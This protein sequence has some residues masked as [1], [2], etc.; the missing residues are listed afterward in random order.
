MTAYPKLF[1]KG[2]I[3]RLELPNR[4]IMAPMATFSHDPEGFI[5]EPTVHYYVERLEEGWG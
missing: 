1:S 3:G 5:Q 4:L 2:Y